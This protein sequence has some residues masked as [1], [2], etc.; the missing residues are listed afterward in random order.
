MKKESLGKIKNYLLVIIFIA[1]VITGV[2]LYQERQED[3][4]KYEWFLNQFYFELTSSVQSLQ[5]VLEKPLRG[6]GL[7]KALLLVE[8]NLERTDSV[9]DSGSNFVD[10]N[11]GHTSIFSNHPIM[12][13]ADDNTLTNEEVRYLQ[14]LKKDLDTIQTGLYSDKTG[15][16]NSNLSV[17]AFNDIISGSGLDSDFLTDRKFVA[18]P[19]Q[20]VEVE[21]T[22]ERIQKW[23]EQNASVEQKKVFLV[24]GRTYV[25]VVS[26]GRQDGFYKVEIT[27]IARTG[28]V[29]AVDYESEKQSIKSDDA[30]QKSTVAIAKLEMETDRSFQFTK[31]LE[32][33]DESEYTEG[34]SSPHV[35]V[36][37]ATELVSPEKLSGSGRI[38]E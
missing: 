29:I 26:G 16:E 36:R 15:Q 13:F 25:L 11:I 8:R 27:D 19:F 2:Q 20:W 4:R 22:P 17:R 9:L 33:D 37:F 12:Q 1:L 5:T 7:E 32:V 30:E 23:I 18:V 24:D 28:S 35:S 14:K 3:K 21:Q 6:K 38:K 34:N 31:P 10:Q